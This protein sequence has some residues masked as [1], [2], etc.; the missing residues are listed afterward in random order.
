MAGGTTRNP[1]VADAIEGAV[2]RRWV[3]RFSDRVADARDFLTQLDAAIGDADHGVNMDRGLRAAREKVDALERD[4]SPGAILE[5]VGTALVFT[6]G[7]AAGP[8]YGGALR[9]A[10]VAL[11]DEPHVDGRW[12][13][14]GLRAALDGIVHVGAAEPGDKTIVDAWTPAL[15]AMDAVLAAGG[16]LLDATG[17]ARIA[18]EEG[19]RAT[20]PLQARKGRASYL[21]ARSIGH[22]D[23]GATSTALLFASLDDVVR[24]SA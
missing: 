24:G 4:A 19:C 5:T 14:V 7:G 6:V 13:L 2:A 8:L 15:V 9:Q 3:A 20:I 10:A 16:T 1:T 17:Q 22:Q 11:G 21:G 12:L 23:P 18:A